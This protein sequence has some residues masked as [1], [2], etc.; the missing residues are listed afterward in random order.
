MKTKRRGQLLTIAPQTLT[1]VSLPSV[2]ILAAGLLGGRENDSGSITPWGEIYIA[3]VYI[4][5]YM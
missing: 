4:S 5:S 2:C 1:P 3:M